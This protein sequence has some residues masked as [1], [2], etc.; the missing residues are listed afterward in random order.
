MIHRNDK[1]REQ[2]I[3]GEEVKDTELRANASDKCYKRQRE[4]EKERETEK[5]S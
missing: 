4:G 2:K 3:K 5:G 1:V